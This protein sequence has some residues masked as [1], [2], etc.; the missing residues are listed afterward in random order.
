MITL[1]KE[2]RLKAQLMV[3]QERAARQAQ[4]EEELRKEI[5]REAQKAKG[6]SM[7]DIDV[8]AMKQEVIKQY[9]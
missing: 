7:K 9:K 2:D 1:T 3:M 6:L 5:Q 4:R 8:E